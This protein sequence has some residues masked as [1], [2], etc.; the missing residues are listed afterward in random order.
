MNPIRVLPKAVYDITGCF[1]H[2]YDLEK[3]KVADR[4]YQLQET[5]IIKVITDLG[6]L[7]AEFYP[8]FEFDGRSGPGIVDWYVPNLGTI[9]E[10]L[11]WLIHDGC[12]Y[13]TCLDF[14]STN[15]LLKLILRDQVGYS[16]FKSSII[17]TAVSLSKSWYGVPD[18][19][20]PWYCNLGKFNL[21]WEGNK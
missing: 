3:Y 16:R 4:R 18:E 8:K 5:V 10:R 12:G 6:K 19:K 7:I 1:Q 11:A 14:K 9:E 2:L 15:H 13:A 21:K 20:D 17:E